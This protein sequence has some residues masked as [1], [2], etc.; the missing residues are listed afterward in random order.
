MMSWFIV[1]ALFLGW[2]LRVLAC[3]RP[4]HIEIRASLAGPIVRFT[5]GSRTSYN[6]SPLGT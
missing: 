4:S 5:L 1:E 2:S 6:F 3:L